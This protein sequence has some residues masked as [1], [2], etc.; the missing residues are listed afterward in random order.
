MRWQLYETSCNSII[1]LK[2]KL[3]YYS[4]RA[5]PDK[6]YSYRIYSRLHGLN[7]H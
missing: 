5:L 3:D 7:M 6:R 1:S 2:T 4:T